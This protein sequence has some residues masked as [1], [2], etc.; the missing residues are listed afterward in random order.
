MKKGFKPASWIYPQPAIVI[1]TWDKEGYADAMT[2]AWAGIYDTDKIGIML[3]HR[4]K[5]MENF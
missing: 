3:D 5:T 2:A 4:H 1:A